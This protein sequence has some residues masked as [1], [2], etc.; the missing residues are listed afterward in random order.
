M[1]NFEFN[2]D[3][4]RKR[5]IVIYKNNLLVDNKD[6]LQTYIER[7]SLPK[8]CSIASDYE[9]RKNVCN[10]EIPF[11]PDMNE[12]IN[13]GNGVMSIPV[14][15][16]IIDELTTVVNTFSSDCIK[17]I[18]GSTEIIPLKGYSIENIAEDIKKA[19]DNKRDICIIR[20]YQDYLDG[21][22]I[23]TDGLEIAIYKFMSDMYCNIAIECV[24]GRSLKGLKKLTEKDLKVPEWL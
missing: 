23:F 2:Y 6:R 9:G 1:Q 12:V 8:N 3:F 22:N 19:I 24:S 7:S 13:K 4:S 18:M 16:D 14:P 15:K 17:K 20:D 5:M 10:I 11:I 21:K